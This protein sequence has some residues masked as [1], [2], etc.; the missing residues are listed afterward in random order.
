VTKLR[1]RH[2]GVEVLLVAPVGNRHHTIQPPAQLFD[3]P[4]RLVVATPTEYDGEG[5]VD[6]TLAVRSRR[7]MSSTDLRSWLPPVRWWR[8]RHRHAVGDHPRKIVADQD[9]V[10]SAEVWLV[11]WLF[12]LDPGKTEEPHY[13]GC[14]HVRVMPTD[15]SG[16]HGCD[17][18]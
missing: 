2:R 5:R 11:S 9:R 16:G 10:T 6:T 12:D 1:S 17:N 4:L 18:A 8:G 7:R 14:F 15:P 13:C 3:Y